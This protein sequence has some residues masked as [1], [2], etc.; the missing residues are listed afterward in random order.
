MCYDE[1]EENRECQV[2]N[3]GGSSRPP[4]PRRNESQWTLEVKQVESL[5]ISKKKMYVPYSLD[6]KRRVEQKLAATDDVTQS[7]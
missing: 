5:M 2:D 7:L 3:G 1:G 6:G 4:Q